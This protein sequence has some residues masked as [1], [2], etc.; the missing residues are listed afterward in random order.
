MLRKVVLI[1]IIA[2]FIAC[3]DG[4][5][6]VTN[7]EFDDINLE[8]C[9]GSSD[10][11]LYKI[12]NESPY[13]SLS[14]KLPISSADFL[15]SVSTVENPHTTPLSTSNTFNYRAYEEDPTGIFCNSLPPSINIT[16]DSFSE[17]G[18]VNFYT[19]LVEDDNDGIPAEFEDLNNNNDY[20]DD[21]TDEDGIPNYLDSDDDG[22]NI[23][24]INEM[25]DPNGDGDLT[26]S[27]DTDGDGIYDYLDEDDD[28]DGILTRNEDSNGNINPAD[29]ITDP[30]I[31]P[32]YLNPGVISS[33]T[34]DVY[35]DH[36]K[37]LDYTSVIYIT[38]MTLINNDTNETIIDENYNFGTIITPT[39]TETYEVSFD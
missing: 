25:A 2:L 36:T 12:K 9:T 4:D 30:N 26:D 37:T 31:G 16:S 22:D 28:G 6:F 21:D 35:L 7:L 18:N 13:E 32:D 24:T 38:N 10:L 33:T 27:R 34:N 14:A 20:N 5:V 3:D 17:S 39:I 11:I 1:A 15:T 8:Y 19:T 29:D 23:P